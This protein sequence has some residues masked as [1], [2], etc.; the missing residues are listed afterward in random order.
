MPS[1]RLLT[2]TSRFVTGAAPPGRPTT[3]GHRLPWQREPPE[4]RIT[5]RVYSGVTEHVPTREPW[6]LKL[7]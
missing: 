6:D 5:W 3:T 7:Y 4:N 2:S 1:S